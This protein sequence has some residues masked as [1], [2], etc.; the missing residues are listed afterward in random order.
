MGRRR[1]FICL[2][3]ATP[4]TLHDLSNGNLAGLFGINE[5]PLQGIMIGPTAGGTAQW[6]RKRAILQHLLE[7]AVWLLVSVGFEALEGALLLRDLPADLP[8]LLII[9][10]MQG[11]QERDRSP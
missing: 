10:P 6:Q 1:V 4:F 2:K 8:Y 11:G 7:G 3:A 9:H 5:D